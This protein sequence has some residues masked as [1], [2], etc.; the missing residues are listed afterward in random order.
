MAEVSDS[1]YGENDGEALSSATVPERSSARCA[2]RRLI[3]ASVAGVLV[4]ASIVG[5]L[6]LLIAPAPA[7]LRRPRRAAARRRRAR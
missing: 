5:A 7:A 6:S 2:G 3:G 4:V 1:I